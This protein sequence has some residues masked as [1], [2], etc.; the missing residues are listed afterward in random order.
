MKYLSSFL[1]L[2][3]FTL[4]IFA[5]YL[6]DF[7]NPNRLIID[8]KTGYIYVSNMNGSPLAKDD[9]GFISR[10]SPDFKIV[11]LRYLDGAL[12]DYEL[13]APK[14]MAIKNGIIYVADINVVRGFDLE[15]RVNVQNI[16]LAPY[17]AKYLV[18]LA[19]TPQGKLLVSDASYNAIF[20]ITFKKGASVRVFLHSPLL[21]SPSGIAVLPD[22]GVLIVSSRGGNI[23]EWDKGKF[24]GL[25]E[26]RTY[27][28]YLE[29]VDYD[30]ERNLYFSDLPLGRVFRL[31]RKGRIST[32]P[33]TFFSPQGITIDRK[34][35]RMF[36][37]ESGID[38][39]D[40]IEME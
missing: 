15:K 17:G 20:E 10:I 16:D 8:K 38:K 1:L 6:T 26:K 9:N 5:F 23:W 29:D 30:K 21:K 32:F 12:N 34:N 2:I 37:V 33:G 4:R 40:V 25:L 22:G 36:V 11:T 14:G 3:L 18:D 28:R 19:F 7:K 24:H 35:K 27:Y 13:D 39:V 31:D